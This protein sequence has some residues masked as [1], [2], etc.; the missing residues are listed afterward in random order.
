MVFPKAAVIGLG[1]MGRTHIQ[2]LRR[3]GVEVHGVAGITEDEAKKAAQELSIP[4]WYRNFDETIA[5]KEIQVVHLCT[6]NNLHFRQAKKALEAG[7]HVLCEKPLAMTSDESRHLAALAK[8]TSLMTAVNYNLRFYPI[9]Q[10]ARARIAAGDLGKP[11]L[12]HGAYLQDWLFL[13]S[14]WNWRLE[15]EQG[16]KLRVVA[17]IGTHWMDLV[18]YLTGLKITAVMATFKTVHPTRLQ[19]AGELETFA[20]KIERNGSSNETAINTEDAAV[21]LFQFENGALGNLSLSQVS[22]GRKNYLWFEISGSKSSF[23]W[24]QENPNELWIGYREQP[25]QILVK[26]PSLFHPEVRK[27]TG[28]PGGHAEGYPDTFVQ[29]F[30]QFYGAIES[31]KMPEAGEFATFADG[32][33]EMLLC[34]AIESSARTGA[35][36]KVR[37]EV[38]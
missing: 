23:C 28:F 7:K 19:P 17:D 20:G 31:G 29:V 4:K 15:P 16:G 9:C 12:V 36:V 35:W 8:E 32:H 5:D 30:R 6:P 22:A 10:E 38:L 33:H 34:E 21:I 14:D 26:D 25:N 1:F 24:D 18:T 2:S 37:Q 3:L 11:Y 27:L 13:K